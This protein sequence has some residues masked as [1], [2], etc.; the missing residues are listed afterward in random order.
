[1]LGVSSK[2]LTAYNVST[3]MCNKLA[4]FKKPARM[5][6]NNVRKALSA[7]FVVED[8]VCFDGC[9][10]PKGY[11]LRFDFYIRALGLLVEADGSQHKHGHPWHSEYHSECDRIKD[12]FAATNGFGLVRIPYSKRV[13]SEYVFKFL[14]TAVATT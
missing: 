14:E 7:R 6:E 5:F 11:P 3:L 2:T 1:M 12:K 4:G 8:E 10:S 13:N 9:V